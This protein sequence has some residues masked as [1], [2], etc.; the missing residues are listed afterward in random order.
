MQLQL[1][2]WKLD[3]IFNKSDK[4]YT[5][6]AIDETTVTD[7]TGIAGDENG[8]EDAFVGEFDV[9]AADCDDGAGVVAA[10]KAQ[11]D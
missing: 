5:P 2:W 10:V 4:L 11:T 9:A 3:G 1:E 7:V 6:V 8:A